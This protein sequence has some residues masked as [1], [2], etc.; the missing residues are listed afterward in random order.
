MTAFGP[1]F[2]IHARTAPSPP[3]RGNISS[4]IPPQEKIAD[5]VT[6]ELDD[7]GLWDDPI[8]TKVVPL[9]A[10]YP[11]EEYHQEYFFRGVCAQ[12]R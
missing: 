5:E 9:E 2:P 3:C 1:S 8:V 7:A 12:C 4:F 11:A 6:A 10:F